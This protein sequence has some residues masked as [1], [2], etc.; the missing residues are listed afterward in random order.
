MT[1]VKRNLITRQPYQPAG[2][3]LVSSALQDQERDATILRPRGVVVTAI[4]RLR[5]AISLRRHA[6]FIDAFVDHVL[7][8]RFRATIRQIEVVRVI[9]A[10]VGVTLDLDQLDAG[11]ALH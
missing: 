11:V 10:L 3:A 7:A 1:S 9:A 2:W 5:L 6:L 8:H 4:D